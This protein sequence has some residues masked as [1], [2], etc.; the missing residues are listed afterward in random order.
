MKKYDREF[1]EAKA[2]AAAAALALRL[3]ELDRDI[4][5]G[6]RSLC[7][8]DAACVSCGLKGTF[9]SSSDTTPTVMH[10]LDKPIDVKVVTTVCSACGCIHRFNECSA[11]EACVVL[12]HHKPPVVKSLQARLVLVELHLQMYQIT[13]SAPS[14]GLARDV[15]AVVDGRAHVWAAVAT[16]F[17]RCHAVGVAES[18]H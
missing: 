11:F 12:L 18:G 14:Y 8:E 7:P 2:K 16:A 15:M 1:D 4:D 5:E 13:T 6:V 9:T 17:G 3:D 10:L